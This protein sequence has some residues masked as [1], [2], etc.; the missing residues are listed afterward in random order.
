MTQNTFNNMGLGLGLEELGQQGLK[1]A[2]T[3]F[4]VSS[5][6]G[7][8][9]G[10]LILVWPQQSTEVATTVVA[11]LLSIFFL[12]LGISRIVVGFSS[13]GGSGWMRVFSI[14]IGILLI[15][16][17]VL[18]LSNIAIF[19]GISALFIITL[20]A[21]AWIIEGIVALVESGKSPSTGWSVFYGIISILG[22]LALIFSPLTGLFVLVW[23]AGLFLV[24]GGIAGF[25]RAHQLSKLINAAPASPSTQR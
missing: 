5:V 13:S 3:W 16:C 1:Q 21:V 23:V 10:I 12:V 7:V 15:V 2:R 20:L 22:G 8:I 11:I 19:T 6:I 17:G 9:L 18:G 24:I 4:R 25:V 14:L